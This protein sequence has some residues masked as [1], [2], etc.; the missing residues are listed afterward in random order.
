MNRDIN[1]SFSGINILQ[2]KVLSQPDT[3][4]KDFQVSTFSNFFLVGIDH[5]TAGVEVREKFSLNEAQAS[6]LISDYK[7]LGGDGMMVVSTCNRTEIYAFG[8]CPRDIISLF[9]KHTGNDHELFY[10]HQNVKQ[11]RDAIE[12]LF[13][14]SS[15]MESKI[16]GDFEIIGQIKKSFQFAREQTAHNAFL[17]RLVNSAIQTSK[18]VKNETQLSTGAA[19]VAFAAVQKVKSYLSGT[20][21]G[22]QAKV[23][24]IGTGKI[25]RTAC[26]NL[27]NQT[28]LK[29]ITLINRTEEKAERLAER[30]G[31]KHQ[32]YSHLQSTLDA[33]DVVIVATGALTPTVLLSHFTTEKPRLILDLSVPRNVELALY[34]DERFEVVDVDKL[35]TITQESMERRKAE[36]PAAI[37]IIHNMIDD[38]YLWLESRRVAPTLQAVRQKMESWKSKEVQNL[39]KKYPELNEEH[40]DILADQ[41]L[42]RITGQFA[43]RLKSGE[44]VNNDLRTIHYIFELEANK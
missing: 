17:E 28:G 12:H 20:R 6:H 39:L 35:S 13:K 27:V 24:L 14:V 21:L 36:I 5:K 15:G 30:F 34:K 16:L 32:D 3:V 37:E 43:K 41:L 25:G 19:S 4:M 42:N 10:R 18:K 31:V 9:C 2:G 38:F 23:A 8:N 40:A 22:E 1:Y 29:D 11:N 26:E 44:D 7:K 33:S